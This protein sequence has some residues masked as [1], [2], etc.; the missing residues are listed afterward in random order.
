MKEGRS[1]L[2]VVHYT[3]SSNVS[4][5]YPWADLIKELETRGVEQVF[6]CRSFGDMA[7]I[8]KNQGIPVVIW[9]PLVTNFP[10]A[11]FAYCRVIRSLKPDIV[12]TRGSSAAAISGFWG[13]FLGVPTIAMLDGTHYKKKYYRRADYLTACSETAKADMVRQGISPE[14]IDVT[15][16]SID[17]GKYSS[18]QGAREK[19]RAGTGVSPDEKLFVAA[20]SFVGVKGFDLLIKAFADL[21]RE[22]NDVKLLLAGDGEEKNYYRRLIE[23]LEISKSVIISESYVDDIRPW[24][25]ASD[26]FVLPSRGEPFGIIILEAMAAGL[27]VIVTDSGGPGEIVKNEESGIVIPPGNTGELFRAMQKILTMGPALLSDMKENMKKRLDRFTVQKHAS[28]LVEIYEK[29]ASR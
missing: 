10:P 26:F 27:P 14:K 20:G 22:R 11:D 29:V 13:P 9:E 23:E 16:N 1:I 15:Y 7:A 5:R 25:W 17:A 19:F 18:N 21:R 8:L 28:Q 3:H 2:K 12:H 24:L 4:F 6:M